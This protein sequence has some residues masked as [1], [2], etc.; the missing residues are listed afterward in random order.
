MEN[1]NK[2]IHAIYDDDDVLLNAVKELRSKK[3]V[4]E[5]L[6][7]AKRKVENY[8]GE[9]KVFKN[10]EKIKNKYERD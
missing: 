5:E 1:K 7:N 10:I 6:N 4:I 3:Y 8:K 9:L 2:T